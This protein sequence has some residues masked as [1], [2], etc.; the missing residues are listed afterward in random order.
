MTTEWTTDPPTEPGYYWY[1]FYSEEEGDEVFWIRDLCEV[2][3]VGG[4]LKV[5]SIGVGYRSM[6][7]FLKDNTYLGHAPRWWPAPADAPA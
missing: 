6:E 5:A 1:Q 3:D 4:A 7:A 2:E